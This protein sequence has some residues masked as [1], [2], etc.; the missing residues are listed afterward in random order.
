VTGVPTPMRALRWALMPGC[1]LLGAC[2]VPAEGG[3]SEVMQRP[4]ERA[5]LTGVRAYDD[6]QYADAERELNRALSAGLSSAKDRALAQKHLAFVYCSSQ[7]MK[8]C[9]SAFRAARAA[10][11]E[12]ALSRAEAGHPL[13][14]PIYKRVAAAP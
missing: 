4:A 5:L 1:L 8:P 11:A 6:G 10:D 12:F 9:E 2:A 7:R 13:W 14:G 3:L